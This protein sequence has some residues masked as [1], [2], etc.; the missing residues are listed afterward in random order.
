MRVGGWATVLGAPQAGVQAVWGGIP[1]VTVTVTVVVADAV[2][3]AVARCQLE[4]GN[5][6]AALVDAHLFQYE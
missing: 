4:V 1:N 3:V 5:R 6:H 2:P